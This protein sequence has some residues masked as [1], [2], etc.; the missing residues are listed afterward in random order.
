VY[1][2]IGG[3]PERFA[4][5]V[6]LYRQAGD[7]RHEDLHVTM[8]AIGLIAP[9]SQD[10][11]ETFYPYWLETMKY[12]AR[13]RGWAIPSRAEYDEYTRGA[14]SF[15]VGS[16]QEVADRLITVGNLPARA[17]RAPDGLVRRAL[18]DVMHAIELLGTEVLSLIRKE[19][20]EVQATIS[21]RNS[22]RRNA[23]R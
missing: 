6:D 15:F 10:A 14:R 21:P 19:F 20:T 8:S 11:K 9:N 18:T 3:R 12:G 2:V 22:P 1:A 13:A 4:P 16:P 23:H 7:H 5:L 17:A